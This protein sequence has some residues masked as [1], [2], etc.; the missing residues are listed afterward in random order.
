VKLKPN[1]AASLPCRSTSAPRSGP[2]SGKL[3]NQPRKRADDQK[4]A[5]V[6]ES[7]KQRLISLTR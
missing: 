7:G 4:A 1:S 3:R 6:A 2:D 5:L